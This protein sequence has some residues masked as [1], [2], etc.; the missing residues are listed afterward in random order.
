MI[1]IATDDVA[2]RLEVISRGLLL[3]QPLTRPSKTS[4]VDKDES[5]C[6]RT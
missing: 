3:V 4:R 6:I 5:A 1:V 2:S